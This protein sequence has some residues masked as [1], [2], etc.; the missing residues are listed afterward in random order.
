M[1]KHAGV[2][3]ATVG[4][5]SQIA[6]PTPDDGDEDNEERAAGVARLATWCRRLLR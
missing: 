3:D 6:V 5:S 2:I 4:H 1:R